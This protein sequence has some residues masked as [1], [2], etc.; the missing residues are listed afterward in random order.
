MDEAIRCLDRGARGIKLHP[1]AQRFLPDDPRLEPVFAV[2]SARKVPILIHGG[3]GLPPIADS[4]ARLVERFSTTLIIAHAGIVDLARWR[5]AL[6]RPR[7]R[8]L[9][10]VRV[11]PA[12]PARPLPARLAATGAL[13]LGLPVRAAAELAAD[14]DPHR[15]RVRGWTTPNCG[16]CSPRALSGS[17]TDCRHCR[18][19]PRGRDEV[20]Q[21]VTFARIHQYLSMA[22]TLLWTRQQDTIG[23]LGLALNACD[24]RANGHREATDR[25]R[26]LLG[27][28]ATSGRSRLSPTT[29]RSGSA[30][31][32]RLPPAPPGEHP[33]RH[34]P[35]STATARSTSAE[36]VASMRTAGCRAAL[37]AGRPDRARGTF[38]T[39][40]ATSVTSSPRCAAAAETSGKGTPAAP[41]PLVGRSLRR[42][43]HRGDD[44]GCEREQRAVVRRRSPVKLEQR[45]LPLA[46]TRADAHGR[47]ARGQ[48]R[49]EIGRVC[50][51]AVPRLE[52]VLAMPICA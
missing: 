16:P 15:T 32:R 50:R 37:R 26:Q 5:G 49:R 23:L 36:Q 19:H 10:H 39:P 31:A 3:R 28:L 33:H 24:E 11:E 35:V 34:E 38:A 7:R 12:R 9:R 4:L 6:Q 41:C 47:P 42:R 17:P 21:P 25:I 14:G 52:A 45:E 8:L 51:D 18:W 22:A 30:T 20:A 29:R 1:R 46:V 44:L 2:A 43:P 40:A 13:R 48:R 27:R